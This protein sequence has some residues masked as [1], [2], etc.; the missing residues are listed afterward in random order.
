PSGG[1]KQASCVSRTPSKGGPRAG[2]QTGDGKDLLA[3]DQGIKFRPNRHRGSGCPLAPATP[4]YMRVRIRRFGG[5]ELCVHQVRKSQ[6]VEVSDRKWRAQGGTVGQPPR[7][8]SLPLLPD[9]G[10]QSSPNP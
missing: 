8:S 4:P 9:H 7:A 1:I 2:A 5:V 10:S 6:G 3:G